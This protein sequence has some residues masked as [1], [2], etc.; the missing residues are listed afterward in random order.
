MRKFIG[1]FAGALILS[2]TMFVGSAGA[3]GTK[4]YK[5]TGQTSTDSGTCGVD[6]AND[7]FQRTFK[8]T[9]QQ[10]QD[11][12]YRVVEIYNKGTF[13]TI[14]A[15]SPQSCEAGNSNTVDGVLSGKFSG[16]LTMK[17]SGGTFDPVGAANCPGQ[18][19]TNTW[20][21]A[22]FGGGATRADSDWA[23]EYSTKTGCARDW[24]NALT[25]NGG[26]IASTCAP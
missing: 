8:V 6:W 4:N 10:A 16:T 11:G 22:A 13:T 5:F 3:S 7:S 20:I 15:A 19:S 18:C 2:T 14:A 9:K 21:A 17:I 25:G 12:S 24:L 23:F 26:D 1:V